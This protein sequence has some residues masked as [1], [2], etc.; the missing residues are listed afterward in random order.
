MATCMFCWPDYVQDSSYKTTSVSGG[1]WDSALSLNNLKD[2]ALSTVARST[3]TSYTSTVIDLD[4]ALGRPISLFTISNHNFSQNATIKLTGS[5]NS[6]YSSPVY[7]TAE[8]DVWP[9]FYPS[10]SLPWG[11]SG[12][13]SGVLSNEETDGYNMQFIHVLPTAT[14]ARY[15]KVEIFDLDNTDGY[16][17]MSR[18]SLWQAWQPLLNMNYGSTLGWETD[19]PSDQ[20]LSGTSY[21]DRRDPKRVCN[22]TLEFIK[23]DVAITKPFEMARKLGKDG[24]LFFV[25]DPDDS[26]GDM[27]RRSFLANMSE[28]SPLEFPVYSYNTQV[29][30]LK[31]IL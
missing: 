17:E 14:W 7:E 23:Y 8:L 29:L 11:Y 10:G 27:F 1:D 30:S 26:Q 2:R 15:W 25:F 5:N 24:E 9:V 4:L 19:T 22:L 6:D 13:W 21:F 3:D 31:E 16:V 18:V 28:L 20:S 12:V